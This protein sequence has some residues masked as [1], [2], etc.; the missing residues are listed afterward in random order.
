SYTAKR[1][2]GGRIESAYQSY[3]VY[4]HLGNLSPAEL[5]TDET[6]GKVREQGDAAPVLADLAHRA[7]RRAA[8][9]RWSFARTLPGA[10]GDVR[11]V[12]LDSRRRRGGGGGRR[13][14]DE[15]ERGV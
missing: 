12:L 9:V 1:W 11:V 14:G 13:L 7:D 4:Q 8:G 5:A 3:W 10:G 6:W 15:G 2:W